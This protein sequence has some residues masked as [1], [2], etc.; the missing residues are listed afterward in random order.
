MTDERQK[1]GIS[2]TDLSKLRNQMPRW[3]FALLALGVAAV[4]ASRITQLIMMLIAATVIAYISS[5]VIGA[6]ERLGI[7]RSVAVILLFVLGAVFV[8]AANLIFIPDLKQESMNAYAK[9]REFSSQIQDALLLTA[10]SSAEKYPF[11]EASIMKLVD[12]VFGPSGFLERTLNASEI[13]MRATPFIVALIV[14]PFFV[15]FLLKDWPVV[16][17]RVMDWVPPSHVETT[18]SVIGEINILV[19]KYLRGLAADSFVIGVLAST[20]LSLIGI[21][22]PILLGIVSGMTNIIPYLGPIT[23]CALSSIVALMQYR[24]FDPVLHVVVLYLVIRLM[25]DLVIQ[26]LLIGKSVQL[27]PM[28]LVITLIVGEKLFGIVG[29]ILGVPAV[30]AAQKTAGILLEHRRETLKGKATGSFIRQPL[31]KSHVRPI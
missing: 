9:L 27:H 30:T 24:S 22:Y 13:L 5:S 6:F 2:L 4:I 19:G 3:V 16:M 23:G 15:F 25:D 18:I 14:V 1:D 10:Q 29:M 8:I 7:K 17:K 26:P 21:N 20:G 12:T 28:L 31:V 11:I